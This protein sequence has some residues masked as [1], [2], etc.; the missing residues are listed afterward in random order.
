MNPG[1]NV[2]TLDPVPV[3]PAC[4]ELP[5]GDRHGVP[6]SFAREAFVRRTRPI[7][8]RVVDEFS[9]SSI[10]ARAGCSVLTPPSKFSFLSR[11]VLEQSR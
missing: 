10:P 6:A 4:T 8:V 5:L 11:L 9:P 7:A 2:L 1:L 3:I